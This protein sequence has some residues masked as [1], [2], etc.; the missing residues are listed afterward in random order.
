MFVCSDRDVLLAVGLSLGLLLLLLLGLTVYYLWRRRKG[1]S[2]YEEL[3]STVPSISACSAPVIPV[4]QSSWATLV[5]RQKVF[6][7]QSRFIF[8]FFQRFIKYSIWINVLSYIPTMSNI[9]DKAIHCLID[10]QKNLKV[11]SSS[12]L[13]AQLIT[14]VS[15]CERPREI[16][17]TLPPRFM[18]QNQCDQ[19]EEE[20]I[21]MEARRD[22]LA[23]RGSLSVSSRSLPPLFNSK[24]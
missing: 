8:P 7:A 1:Q 22:I 9:Y 6:H 16:P 10:K 20:V 11:Y 17:F 12:Y 5:P 14:F 19:K 18:T 21:K 3:L 15:L 4:S 2:Q 23:H 13:K 24:F